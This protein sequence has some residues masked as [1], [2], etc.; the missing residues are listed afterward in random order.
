MRTATEEKSKAVEVLSVEA[1]AGYTAAKARMAEIGA[2]KFAVEDE[3]RTA[4]TEMA[5]FEAARLESAAVN[6]T[7]GQKVDDSSLHAIRKIEDVRDRL[8]V[9]TRAIEIQG[10]LVREMY[11]LACAEIVERVKPEY[12]QI[13]REYFLT[14]IALG[15]LA[16]ARCRWIGKVQ[17]AGVQGKAGGLGFGDVTPFGSVIGYPSTHSEASVNWH[18]RE[19]LRRGVIRREEVPSN[20]K[21]VY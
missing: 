20:W 17:A 7:L 9:V 6:L 1:H 11:E 15:K 12:L 13:E 16:D 4:Q 14:L 21:W 8:K 2:Q 10:K 3:L 18:L 5:K 19:A